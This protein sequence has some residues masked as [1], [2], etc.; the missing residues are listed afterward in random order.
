MPM[1]SAF[2]AMVNVSGCVAAGQRRRA[3]TGNRAHAC[4]PPPAALR[5]W[6]QGVDGR[7]FAVGAARRRLAAGRANLA[8]QV[9]VATRRDMA[10]ALS[11]LAWS[12][13][14]GSTHTKSL[15]RASR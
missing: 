10:A 14:G 7:H 15:E 13:E 8:R 3:P 6:R 11:A 1:H 2:L 12:R 5:A 4:A 9:G